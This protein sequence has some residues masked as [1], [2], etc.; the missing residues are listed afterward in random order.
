MRITNQILNRRVL[1]GLQ[2][3]LAGLDEAQQ[4]A[5]TGLRVQTASDDPAGFV[6]IV[7]TDRRLAALEQYRRGIASAKARLDA[8]EGA[9]DQLTDLLTRARELAMSQ[10]GSSGSAS[11]RTV[12]KAEVDQI[13]QQVISLGNTRHGD[14][15]LFGGDFAAEAPFAADGSTSVARPPRG[16]RSVEIGAGQ[17]SPTNH[18]GLQVFVDSGVIAA[19]QQLSVGLADDSAAGIG[20]SLSALVSAFDEVQDV[21]GETGARSRQLD[22][23]GANVDTLETSLRTLRADLSEVDMEQAI[24]QLISRQTAYQAALMSTSRLM[25]TTLTD[26]LR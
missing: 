13:L 25:S 15:Y 12:T 8:E 11:T 22:M 5:V 17:T 9:L 10:S 2:Q 1:D 19:L 21:L 26:Y 3:N 16:N 23:A 7:S 6:G 4:R 18:D 20:A 14:G 24:S